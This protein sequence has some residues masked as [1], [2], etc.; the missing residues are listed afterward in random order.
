MAKRL[1]VDLAA[2][3]TR[4]VA[5]S[6]AD[7]AEAKARRAKTAALADRAERAAAAIDGAALSPA[8]AAKLVNGGSLTNPERD[9]VLRWLALR[10]GAGEL[11]S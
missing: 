4:H 8:V 2:G 9:A 7:M 11:I 1:V 6:A 5:Q 10:V 3:K